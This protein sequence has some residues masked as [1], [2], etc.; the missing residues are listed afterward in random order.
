MTEHGREPRDQPGR[1]TDQAGF[2]G[3]L[4]A[5]RVGVAADREG[6]REPREDTQEGGLG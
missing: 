5:V 1:I 2:D 6:G 4:Q 3:E